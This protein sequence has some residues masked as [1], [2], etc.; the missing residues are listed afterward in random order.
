M[1]PNFIWIIFFVQPLAFGNAL[2]H[3]APL[4]HDFLPNGDNLTKDSI[5]PCVK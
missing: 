2:T 4:E 3:A 5:V 1:G